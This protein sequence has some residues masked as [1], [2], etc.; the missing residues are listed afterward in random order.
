MAVVRPGVDEVH[1]RVSADESVDWHVP[2][3]RTAPSD[4]H[5]RIESTRVHNPARA[6]AG[7]GDDRDL[8]LWLQSIE[9]VAGVGG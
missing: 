1:R 3:E 7:S 2:F 9:L 6:G 5:L 8:V 4:L